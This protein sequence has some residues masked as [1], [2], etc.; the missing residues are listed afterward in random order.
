ME[1]P[2]SGHELRAYEQRLRD[3]RSSLTE[4]MAALESTSLEPPGSTQL[5]REDEALEE[6]SLEE[7]VTA[8]TSESE[9]RRAV[10]EALER[11]ADGS[12]G[13]CESCASTI[14]RERLALVPYARTCVAC[15]RR[16][17]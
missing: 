14:P 5:A 11:I 16:R 3:L 10:D 7:G 9:L 15:A 8:L 1:R 6:T 13:R 12:F 17:E 2:L 4:T